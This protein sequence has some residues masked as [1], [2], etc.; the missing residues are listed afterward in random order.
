MLKSHD[1]K[2]IAG[3]RKR[4]F[5]IVGCGQSGTTSLTRIL[6][7]TMNRECAVEPGPNLVP[8]SSIRVV[9]L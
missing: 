7:T 4:L 1:F 8:M 9:Q 2:K 3:V 6:N 5:L